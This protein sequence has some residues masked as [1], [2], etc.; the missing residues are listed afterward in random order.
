MANRIIIRWRPWFLKQ[1]TR[2][3]RP[4]NVRSRNPYDSMHV[5]RHDDKFIAPAACGGNGSPDV[6]GYDPNLGF[7]KYALP[8]MRTDR[9]EICGGLRIIVCW[10]TDGAAV[11]DVRVVPHGAT[12]IRK[13]VDGR[14]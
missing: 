4:Y 5:V 7:V 14:N 12:M 10:Q 9:H 8:F 11:V 3:P 13:R 2:L 1:T 6:L